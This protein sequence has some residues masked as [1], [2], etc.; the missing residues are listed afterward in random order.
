MEDYIRA[1]KKKKITVGIVIILAIAI[2]GFAI[3]TV[4][5]DEGIFVTRYT[6]KMQMNEISGLQTGAPVHLAGF[7]VGTVSDIQFVDLEGQQKIEVILRVKQRMQR[8]ITT[9][10]VARIATMGLVGDKYVEIS[11]GNSEDPCLEDNAVLKSIPPADITQILTQGTDMIEDARAIAKNLKEISF[12]L[13]EGTGTIAMLLNDPWLYFDIDEVLFTLRSL[14]IKIDKGEGSLAKLVNDPGLYQ[15][16]TDGLGDLSALIDTLQTGSG[17]LQKLMTDTT[18]YAQL[19]TA[20]IRLNSVIGK[21]EDP[22]NTAGAILT[23]RELHQRLVSA[24]KDLEILL[25]DIKEN[26]KRYL[27]FSIF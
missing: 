14:A 6:L 9:S 8:R 3:L 16:L 15:N 18:F 13:N 7:R 26:P 24:L 27:K 1:S 21:L 12:K 19:N 17:S 5:T 25:A 4:G 2:I 10:A 23:D 22:G 20:V 11:L